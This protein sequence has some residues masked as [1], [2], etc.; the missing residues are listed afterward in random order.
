M[1]FAALISL[2]L[3]IDF[4]EKIDNF[5]EKGKS[6]GLILKFFIL[7][8]PFIVEQ[9]SPV[10]VLLAGVITLGVLNHTNELIALK[11][12]GIPLRKIVAPIVAAG[13]VCILFFL[14]L[15]QWVLPRTVSVTNEIWNKE[16][17]GRVSLGIYRNGRYYYRGKEGF[18]SFMR[19]NPRES[20][21]Y[22]F[23]Y[24]TWDKNYELDSIISS[25]IAGWQ[26]KQW[27]LVQGQVQNKSGPE[28]YSTEVFQG[29]WLAFPETPDSFFVP[30]YRSMELSLVELYRETKNQNSPEES[31]RAWAE[32]FG[33]ISYTTLGFPLLLLG[34]PLLLIVYRK[35]GRDLSLAVPVSCGM[36]FLCWGLWATLQSLAKAN[37]IN[38]LVAAVSV[39]VVVG[40]AGLFFLLREDI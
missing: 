24:S 22:F 9:M 2:Y 15:S 38:P 25:R 20:L 33:R 3:L 39:H 11:S 17:Q 32:F 26:N 8:I 23:S 18:Y 30:A 27:A 35:W 29:K 19:P 16:V 37:Y 31:N 28:R 40:V 14:A 6:A 1:L 36:A 21:F 7:N 4:F 12:C 34:L 13:M 10:C 5:L